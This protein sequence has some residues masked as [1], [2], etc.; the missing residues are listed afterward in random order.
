MYIIM[1]P[2]PNKDNT[3]LLIDEKDSKTNIYASQNS[4]LEIP[5]LQVERSPNVNATTNVVMHDFEIGDEVVYNPNIVPL[6]KAKER[7]RDCGRVVKIDSHVHIKISSDTTLRVLPY[8]VSHFPRSWENIKR[9]HKKLLS[10]VL[11][12]IENLQI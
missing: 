11:A 2:I 4:H 1:L 7:P 12:C 6:P 3:Q 10:K 8:A 9:R 5:K